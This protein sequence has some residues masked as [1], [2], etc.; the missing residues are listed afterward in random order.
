MSFN[1]FVFAMPTEKKMPA[2]AA[3]IKW[4]DQEWSEIATWLY[5]HKGSGL[6]ASATLEEIKA[7]DV[8]EA[9]QTLPL[10][11]QRRQI[12]IAQGFQGIRARLRG[13]FGQMRQDDLFSAQAPSSPAFAAAQMEDREQPGAVAAAPAAPAQAVGE[14]DGAAAGKNS[15]VES[16]RPLVA[17]L[18]E[19][20]AQ[21][22]VRAWSRHDGAGL[23]APLQAALAAQARQGGAQPQ[24]PAREDA[25]AADE[26]FEDE[27][28]ALVEMQPLFDP[29]L[30]PSANSDFK[31]VIGLVAA[32]AGEYAE[33]QSLYPQLQLAIVPAEAIRGPEAF[34]NCQRIIGVHNE[35]PPATDDLLRH[36]LRYRY[37]RLQGGAAQVREQLNAWLDN[38]G[39]INGA[40]GAQPRNDKQQANGR[41][42]SKWPPRVGR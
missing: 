36:S 30:P 28:R 19:E 25:H 41:R 33:L 7:K 9:Q 38:P 22:L 4:S 39:S 12:S 24:H 26:A 37:V 23:L 3:A 31:P 14:G 32:R 35:V 15:L 11:R 34:R 27:A 18:C 8:F 40:P 10:E 42:R 13:I 17:M 5:Q 6:L 1:A 21:A 16:A 2:P 29:K 20:L